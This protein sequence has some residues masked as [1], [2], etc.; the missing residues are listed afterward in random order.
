MSLVRTVVAS[1]LAVHAL[2]AA[3]TLMAQ[4]SLTIYNDGRVLARRTLPLALPKGTSTQRL[5]LGPFEPGSLVP[6]DADVQL[7]RSEYEGD[8]TAERA[9][10]RLVGR[11]LT[12][13]RPRDGAGYETFQVTLLGVDPFRYRLPDGSV[14]FDNPGGTIRF[15]ADA[16]AD[17]GVTATLQSGSARKEL[18]VG[19]FTSGA[20]WRAAYDVVLAD[21]DARVSG[22]AVI[23]SATLGAQDADVQL[24]AGSVSRAMPAPAPMPYAKGARAQMSMDVANA[25]PEEQRTGEFHLYSLP[26]RVTIV[27][28]ATTTVALF[29]PGPV[30]YERRYVV[31][32]VMPLWGFVPQQPEET[33][34]PV[35]VSYTLKRPRGTALGDQP[36]PGGIARL[37]QADKQGRLQLVG[38]AA[39]GHTP[40]GEPVTLSAGEAFDLTAKRTQAEYVTTQEKTKNGTRTVAL[41][42]WKVALTNATDTTA[43]VDVRE[44][45][46]GEWS[47]VSSSVAPEK[48]SAQV[49]RF[50]VP[51][52]ARGSAELTY[53]VKV[54][55]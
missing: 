48:L 38:E 24:L 26:G 33:P 28:G 8:A 27:P 51:V 5:A 18:K 43:T 39:M 22:S 31:R 37:Y 9:L 20:S 7:L 17:P 23:E 19:Y 34:V 14:V 29:E 46:G 2:G 3:G 12:V 32:G 11:Q 21:R 13:E 15:P 40:A 6:L 47:V 41:V 45:R 55:W 54:V 25:M 36:M 42:T 50:R 16:V 35:E 52:P 4:T 10:R 49:T 1:A 30:A 44:E 53:Q